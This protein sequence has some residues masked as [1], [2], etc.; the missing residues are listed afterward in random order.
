MDMK[1]GAAEPQLTARIRYLIGSDEALDRSARKLARIHLTARDT[2]GLCGGSGEGP[3]ASEHDCERCSGAGV[4]PRDISRLGEQLKSWCADMVL[5]Q[6]D[7][8]LQLE[9][10]KI[11]IEMVDWEELAVDYLPDGTFLGD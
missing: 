3:L 5:A 1:D 8:E 6:T 10:L 11:A 4:L 9:I 7:N 2:C